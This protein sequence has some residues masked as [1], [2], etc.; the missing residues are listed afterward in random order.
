[1]TMRSGTLLL[2]LLAAAP[3]AQAQEVQPDPMPSVATLP[4]S[5][6]D[7]WVFMHESNPHNAFIGQTMII[8]LAS[9]NQN[10]KGS[11]QSSQMGNFAEATVRPELYANE[12]VYSR[13]LYGDRTDL[14]VIYDKASLR[15]TGEI[16][17]PGGK[18]GLV[19]PQKALFRLSG[20]ERFALVYNFTPAASVTIVDLVKR[21]IADEVDIPGCTMIYPVAARSFLS[22]CGDG[23]AA[24]ITLGDDG[25]KL[26]EELSKPF[27]DIDG[28]PLF[29]DSALIDGKRYFVSY[30]GQVTVV[31]TEGGKFKAFPAWSLNTPADD[32][33]RWAPSGMQI[34]S[35]DAQGRLHVL[36]RKDK[37]P[38]EEGLGGNEVWI[39]DVQ[40]RQRIGRIALPK[41]GSVIEVTRGSPA[42]LS[43]M[44]DDAEMEVYST[45]T[46]TLLR[47]I[48]G[49]RNISPLSVY[50]A[51]ESGKR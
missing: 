2:A 20:D 44:N 22:L 26:S 9:P 33:E 31:G 13:G 49:W 16:V 32:R 50:A 5:Y 17:L 23:S 36:M 43:V 18:R 46:G 25:R 1:M 10:L 42:L 37:K 51:G 34:L 6:P 11:I 21:S 40:R 12:T 24:L 41:G 47:R 3:L 27:N 38:G 28:D 45:D 19:R 14:I 15:P 48:G 29:M 4:G 35:A 30:K 39:Y 7:S 8:D